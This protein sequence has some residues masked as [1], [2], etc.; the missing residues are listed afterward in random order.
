[1][2]RDNA[3]GVVE[4]GMSHC[5]FMYSD[6]YPREFIKQYIRTIFAVLSTRLRTSQF[7]PFLVSSFGHPKPLSNVISDIQIKK[8][9]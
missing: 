8:T 3:T 4:H 9:N 7:A 6:H 2:T 5:S 1:M